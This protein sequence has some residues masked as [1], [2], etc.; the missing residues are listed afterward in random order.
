MAGVAWSKPTDPNVIVARVTEV[1]SENNIQEKAAEPGV[2]SL[3][4]DG[5]GGR[6]CD[7]LTNPLPQYGNGYS[8]VHF[9]GKIISTTQTS[10]G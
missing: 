4:L 7:I 5:T 9:G 8:T 6:H 10:S 3:N 1:G 2:P